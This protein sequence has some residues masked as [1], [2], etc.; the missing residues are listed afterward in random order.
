MLVELKALLYRYL[1]TY[2][3]V[4]QRLVGD[5]LLA[6][7]IAGAIAVSQLGLLGVLAMFI[8]TITVP[9]TFLTTVRTTIGEVVSEKASGIKEYLKLNGLSSFT[10]QLYLLSVSAIK[11]IFFTSFIVLGVVLSDVFGAFYRDV[12]TKA[13]IALSTEDMIQVYVLCAF[14]TI[15]FTLF[16]STFF[17]DSKVASSVGGV[18]Y[19]TL[20]LGSFIIFKKVGSFYYYLVCLF[21]QS[22]LS[23]CLFLDPKKETDA[24]TLIWVKAIMF[25][26]FFLYLV[27]FLYL[28]QV[29]KD[30]NGIRKPYLFFL[31]SLRQKKKSAS[32]A[33]ATETKEELLNKDQ[34][35]T[36]SAVHHEAIPDIRN[37]RRAV[38]IKELTKRFGSFSAVDKVSLSIYEGQIFCLLGHNGAG[39]TTTIRMLTGMLGIDEGEVYYNSKNFMENFEQIRTKIGI[40]A[41]QDILFDKLKVRE[42]LEL[43]A[44]LRRIPKEEIPDAVNL[45]LK[46]LNLVD[47]RNKYSEQLSGGNKRKLSLAMA[48]VGQT[49]VLFLDEPTSGMDPQNRRV[50]WYHLKQLKEQGLTILLTTHHLDEADELADRIGI[51]SRGKLLAVGTSDFFKKKFGVGYYLSLTPIYEKMKT[52]SFLNLKPKLQ[53]IISNAVPETKFDDQMASDVVKC[54]TLR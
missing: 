10:Y 24:S 54:S 5:I 12:D 6:I 40:C 11:T 34:T 49:K 26:D 53:K 8:Y 37:L 41:Q 2:F 35:D 23:L 31:D 52:Q 42:H 17:S 46:K 16:L 25:F 45:A 22:A 15:S 28:D 36:S 27:A 19:I 43:I 18:V 50:M 48:V 13:K 47:E 39:K 9:F 14:A 4:P 29:M 3:R 44:K 1:I 21:P 7:I 51:M 33:E 30:E 20:S 38:Q 32:S